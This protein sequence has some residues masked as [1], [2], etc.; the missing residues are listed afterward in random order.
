MAPVDPSE[1]C[2]VGFD[3]SVCQGLAVKP[4]VGGW[5]TTTMPVVVAGAGQPSAVLTLKLT[6]HVP[7]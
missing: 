3:R 2:T 5:C 7:A 1:K 4:A 6:G